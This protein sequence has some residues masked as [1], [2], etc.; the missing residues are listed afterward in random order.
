MRLLGVFLKAITVA[1]VTCIF[2]TAVPAGSARA[3]ELARAKVLARHVLQ[4]N[5]VLRDTVLRD[6][7]LSNTALGA[8]GVT[9]AMGG[10][11]DLH[12]SRP[13][14]LPGSADTRPDHPP[15]LKVAVAVSGAASLDPS[16][17]TDRVPRLDTPLARR[18]ARA[19]HRLQAESDWLASCARGACR[20]PRAARWHK[21]VALVRAAPFASRP[22]L[23]QRLVTRAIRYLPDRPTDDHWATPLATLLRG[24]GDCEDH[25]LLKRALLIAAGY[26]EAETRILILRTASGGGHMV[27]Q[28][29]GKTPLILDNRYRYPVSPKTLTGD[30]IAAVAVN[31]GYFSVR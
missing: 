31:Q 6:T 13:A 8:A 2:L 7:A 17:N 26:D 12:R 27:L 3:S 28:V 25:V 10:L 24:A 29:G 20:D 14:R 18:W 15:A 1:W 16:M 22:A 21:T 11:R 19:R 9:G 30:R 5:P 23:A 4:K